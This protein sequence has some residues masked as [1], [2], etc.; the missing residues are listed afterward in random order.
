MAALGAE[1]I[2]QHIA[3]L[4]LANNKAKFLATLSAQLLERH[5]GEVPASFVE[6]EKLAGCA[7]LLVGVSCFDVHVISSSALG[8]RRRAWSC[9]K[10]S[11]SQP[12]RWTPTFGGLRCV[13]VPCTL[14]IDFIGAS[15]TS[16]KYF[17][18]GL[19]PAGLHGGGCGKGPEGPVSERQ[20]EPAPP[21]HDFFRP[22]ALPRAAPRAGD[23]PHLLLRVRSWGREKPWKAV[24]GIRRKEAQVRRRRGQRLMS[25]YVTWS[26]Q[27]NFRRLRRNLTKFGSTSVQLPFLRIRAKTVQMATSSCAGAL[28]PAAATAGPPVVRA[29]ALS[30]RGPARAAPAPRPRCGLSV[31]RVLTRAGGQAPPDGPAEAAPPAALPPISEALLVERLSAVT[32]ARQRASVRIA[33]LEAE[34]R[35]RG[36]HELPRWQCVP[37]R[38]PRLTRFAPRR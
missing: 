15:R 13:C 9:L 29:R 26:C 24:G 36:R 14:Y 23:V 11:A 17:A 12:S 30:S 6:L 31:R 19:L 16:P 21:A 34:A 25:F 1:N 37:T 33:S 32:A 7:G 2:K 8:T 5:G 3:K 38:C 20:M 28:L 27:V 4:G 18:V 35:W 22:G 10:R